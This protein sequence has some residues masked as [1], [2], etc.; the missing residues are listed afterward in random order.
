MSN[1]VYLHILIHLNDETISYDGQYRVPIGEHLLNFLYYTPEYIE[2]DLENAHTKGNT[3]HPFFLL[4]AE[5]STKITG[6]LQKLQFI[7]RELLEHI[8]NA[9]GTFE[10]TDIEC[11]NYFRHYH[12]IA[13]MHMSLDD[14]NAMTLDYMTK[15]FEDCLY[16]ELSEMLR[17]HKILKYCKNCGRL[18][19][20]PKGNV[21]YCQRIFT[22]DGKTCAQVGYAQTFAKSVRNDELLQAYTRA[23]KA[24]YARMTKPR[25]RAANMT[26]DDFESWY[27]EAKLNLEKARQGEIAAEAFYEWLKK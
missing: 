4:S 1:P 25:K 6:K 2:A 7:Y 8:A 15:D 12:C 17:R 20:A 23:Y 5:Q 10:T 13:S 18:F 14:T 16:I 26:R 24:H 19:I 21:D 11:Q 3:I 27:K 22:S 9:D